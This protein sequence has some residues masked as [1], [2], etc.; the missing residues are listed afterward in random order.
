MICIPLI[1][2]WAWVRDGVRVRVGDRD[3]DGDRVKVLHIN[4]STSI[5]ESVR[6]NFGAVYHKGITTRITMTLALEPRP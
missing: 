2:G 4:K 5:S 3:R 6:V 1:S